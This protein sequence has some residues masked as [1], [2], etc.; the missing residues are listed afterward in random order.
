MNCEDLIVE[1]F[2]GERVFLSQD[3]SWCI[4]NSPKCAAGNRE[5]EGSNRGEGIKVPPGQWGADKFHNRL[6]GAGK[7]D[8]QCLQ[9][10]VEP[11]CSPGL[12]SATRG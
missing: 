12:M 3:S 2:L 11:V 5:S 10:C 6:G 7:A 9:I 8:Q 1:I 4:I